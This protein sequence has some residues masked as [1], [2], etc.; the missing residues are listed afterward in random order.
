MV[1]E[2]GQ[3]LLQLQEEALAGLV[4]S[5]VGKGNAAKEAIGQILLVERARGIGSRAERDVDAQDRVARHAVGRCTKG[6][7][8]LAVVDIAE[9]LRDLLVATTHAVGHLHLRQVKIHRAATLLLQRHRILDESRIRQVRQAETR[10]RPP[11]GQ[12]SHG[13]H[14]GSSPDAASQPVACIQSHHG[15]ET[16]S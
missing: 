15:L 10:S 2:I 5:L 3:A 13:L 14:H 4:A 16:V 8:T 7:G 6:S 11:G 1:D 9:H 12:V